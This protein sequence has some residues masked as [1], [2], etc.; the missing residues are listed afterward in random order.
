ME[1]LHENYINLILLHL[2]VAHHSKVVNI[3]VGPS[4]KGHFIHAESLDP[5][6]FF[7]FL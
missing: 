4:A 2:K 3:V 6:F 5:E 7:F 1:Y